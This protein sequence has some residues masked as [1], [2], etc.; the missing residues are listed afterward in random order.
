MFLPDAGN[1]V[2]SG[3][4]ADGQQQQWQQQQQQADGAIV[5]ADLNGDVYPDL[6]VAGEAALLVA[7]G[8]G[9][10]TYPLVEIAGN[11]VEALTTA[12]VDAN[13]TT[14]LVAFHPGGLLSSYLNNGSG[15]FSTGPTSVTTATSAGLLVTADFNQDGAADLAAS[16]NG[17]SDVG[18][19][20]GDGAG[21]FTLDTLVVSVYQVRDLAVL[22]WD[23]D[24]I[25]D[26]VVPE[27]PHN[28]VRI[29]SRQ[30]SGHWATTIQA[31][32]NGQNQGGKTFAVGDFDAQ[33]GDDL[34]VAMVYTESG[35]LLGEEDPPVGLAFWPRK[36]LAGDIDG[37]GW[38]DV[39]NVNGTQTAVL[40]Q[41]RTPSAVVLTGF[42]A[43]S[44]PGAIR[45]QWSAM[46]DADHLGYILERRGPGETVFARITRELIGA[47][48]EC[49]WLDVDVVG[50]R[51]YAYRLGAVDRR[52]NE[53]WFGPIEAEALAAGAAVAGPALRLRSA[54][55]NPFAIE[56][57]LELE[58]PGNTRVVARIYDVRGHLIRTLAPGADGKPNLIRWDG[59]DAAGNAAPS[60]VYLYKL[61]SP[62]AELTGKFVRVT[63]PAR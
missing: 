54:A 23:G 21:R 15:S 37:D 52:G 40:L 61:A 9:F 14:D 8:D 25:P 60:G 34:F 10:T 55:P 20:M 44:E 1:R 39:V 58:T 3:P 19:F 11:A 2:H 31:V 57:M 32:G 56:V 24:P 26:L 47:R 4:P 6:A 53:Q 13:G 38:A 18:I 36:L 27:S 51:R 62:E 28:P 22:D 59:R 50:G 29:M 48:N 63:T 30:P 7:L 43:I 41:V 12:D 5:S 49:S 46:A 35:V 45:I 42:H 16:I 17:D 33:A